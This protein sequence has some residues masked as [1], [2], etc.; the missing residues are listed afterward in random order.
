VFG[1]FLP[2]RPVSAR[3]AA[4]DRLLSAAGSTGLPLVLYEAP[5]RLRD[6]IEQLGSRAPEARLAVGR[7]LTKRFE[8]VVTGSPAEVATRI[9]EPRGEFTVVVSNVSAAKGAAAGLDP[10]GVAAAA[11]REGLSNRTVTNLLRGGG[12]SR[13]DAYAIAG[14]AATATEGSQDPNK[15]AVRGR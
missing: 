15:P 3:A 7:E 5:R 4:L 11:S 6:L 10:L 2:A 12:L 14:S 8:E 13:R 9:A 1:G